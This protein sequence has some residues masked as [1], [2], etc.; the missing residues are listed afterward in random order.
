MRLFKTERPSRDKEKAIK[1]MQQEPM[2][3]LTIN[4]SYTLKKRLKT[5]ALNNNTT[6]TDIILSY[7]EKYIKEAEK[8]ENK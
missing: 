1:L 4:I 3:R 5:I 6:V 7:A 2:D 8:K